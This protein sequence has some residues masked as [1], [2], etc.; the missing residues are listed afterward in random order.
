MKSNKDLEFVDWAIGL[1]SSNIICFP[2]QNEFQVHSL[3]LV[4]TYPDV[5]FVI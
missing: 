3:V 5:E 4:I 1:S 2:D